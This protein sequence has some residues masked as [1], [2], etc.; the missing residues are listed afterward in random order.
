MIK[1]ATTFHITVIALLVFAFCLALVL[2]VVVDLMIF[3]VDQLAE[4]DNVA[5]PAHTQ[6]IRD[7]FY[8]NAGGTQARELFLCFWLALTS[9]F[10]WLLLRSDDA[11][12]YRLNLAYGFLLYF[13]VVAAVGTYFI[14]AL[15]FP[16]V[17]IYSAI[18][19][20]SQRVFVPTLLHI[21]FLLFSA[22]IVVL[23]VAI[24]WKKAK[25]GRGDSS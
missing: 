11:V 8:A 21:F 23:L 12:A 1:V 22:S 17:T 6:F 24:I 7:H 14:A 3:K 16:Y 19:S 2:G 20:G 18:G 25:A 13:A 5:L 15:L 10:L 9:Y 4:L